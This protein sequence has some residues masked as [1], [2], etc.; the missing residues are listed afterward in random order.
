MFHRVLP[1]GEEC[2]DPELVTSTDAFAGFLDW[3]S[4][5]YRVLPIDELV[6]YRGKSANPRRP[7]CA[8]TFDDGW[9][10]NY[11][12]AFPLLYDRQL[13]AT[14]FLP[15]RFIGTTRR[16]WQEQLWLAMKNLDPRLQRQ[17]VLVLAPAPESPPPT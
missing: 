8:I 4:E 13:P 7:L 17:L 16:F 5:N 14:I 1:Q 11:L 2:Y 3:L 9:V 15:L 6:A 12:H 10:D